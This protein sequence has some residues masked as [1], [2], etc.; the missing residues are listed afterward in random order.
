MDGGGEELTGGVSGGVPGVL[1]Y[2]MEPTVTASALDTLTA[3][4]PP[5]ISTALAATAAAGIAWLC[6]TIPARGPFTPPSITWLMAC[7]CLMSGW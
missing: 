7:C 5:V 6:T 4:S 3:A 2:I 1:G